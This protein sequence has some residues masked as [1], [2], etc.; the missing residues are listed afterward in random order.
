MGNRY[1]SLSAIQSFFLAFSLLLPSFSPLLA[2]E[3]AQRGW[4]TRAKE[5]I[6]QSVPQI[7]KQSIEGIKRLTQPITEK[8]TNQLSS[9]LSAVQQKIQQEGP[10]ALIPMLE[11]ALTQ[12]GLKIGTVSACMLRQEGCTGSERAA[13]IGSA[14]LVLALTAALIG[15]TVTVA[16][17]AQEIEAQTSRVSYEVQGWG[18]RAIFN[19][20]KNTVESFKETLNSMKSCLITRQCTKGQKKLLYGTAATIT[21][22]ATIAVGIGIGS[23]IYA[24]RNKEL[25]QEPVAPSMPEQEALSPIEPTPSKDL[26]EPFQEE[27]GGDIETAPSRWQQFFN[28]TIGI[29]NPEPLKRLYTRISDAVKA[30]TIKTKEKIADAYTDLLSRTQNFKELINQTF[31]IQLDKL[32]EVF[33]SIK[34]SIAELG[35]IISRPSAYYFGSFANQLNDL[36]SFIKDLLGSEQTQEKYQERQDKLDLR[37]AQLAEQYDALVQA[38]IFNKP[39]EELSKSEKNDLQA[40]EKERTAVEKAND[41]LSKAKIGTSVWSAVKKVHTPKAV[42]EAARQIIEKINNLDLANVGALSNLTLQAISKLI[43]AGKRL[44]TTAGR[45][46]AIISDDHI[47]EGLDQLSSAI[48]SLGS[49]IKN[50][51]AI[52]PLIIAPQDFKTTQMIKGAFK[53][54]SGDLFKY[55]RQHRNQIENLVPNIATIT[56]L[57]DPIQIAIG[58]FKNH[59]ENISSNTKDEFV[60]LIKAAPLSNI[61]RAATVLQNSLRVSILSTKL[62]FNNLLEKISKILSEINSIA[63]NALI[64]LAGLDKRISEIINTKF[65]NDGVTAQLQ[66]IVT[67]LQAVYKAT[68]A[69]KGDVERS[70]IELQKK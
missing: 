23:Y 30:G 67:D 51:V 56:Q 55:L 13:F 27:M 18:A 1:S 10:R 36:V 49:N 53:A 38:G 44:H 2:Q 60:R 25:D 19:R 61:P 39:K 12:F 3:P 40:Y 46:G 33:G 11:K 47:Q 16:T 24:Q 28:S 54:V 9:T 35:Q 17:T 22:L 37:I 14:I 59:L 15:Y 34:D 70:D 43:S 58:V 26:L 4:F 6:S 41:A 8:I 52:R 21:A 5:S 32:K 7:A 62:T 29:A 68:Q 48:A 31:N 66:A 45:I 57:I 63:P 64:L 65:F 50:L 42:N 20:L 69:L